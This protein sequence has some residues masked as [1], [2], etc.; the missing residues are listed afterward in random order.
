MRI[1]FSE[2]LL[3]GIV[4]LLFFKPEDMKIMSRKL[5]EAC[6]QV[7]DMQKEINDIEETETKGEE[8]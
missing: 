6:K 1:G 4:V 3:I 5:G 2:L 7:K 8:K